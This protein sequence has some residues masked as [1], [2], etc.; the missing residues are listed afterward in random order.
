M[1]RA[2]DLRDLFNSQ[3][4]RAGIHRLGVSHIHMVAFAI[5][6]AH[7]GC[8]QG[9]QNEIILAAEGAAALGFED[10][11]HT[12]RL[13][14]N[15][16][17]FPDD[18][19]TPAKQLVGYF[20]PQQS[21]RRTSIDVVIGDETAFDQT[22]ISHDFKIG[23][24]TEQFN[25]RGFPAK[26]GADTAIDHRRHPFHMRRLEDIVDCRNVSHGQ[27]LFIAHI[28]GEVALKHKQQIGA[29]TAD[30]TQ[31]GILRAGADCQH[32]DYRGNADDDAKDGQC[33]AQFI[34]QDTLKRLPDRL[35]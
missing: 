11:N 31:N 26:A 1:A 2:Q 7:A 10:A 13:P 33:G 23:G 34:G 35:G 15:S 22:V 21:H 6:E 27:R 8:G 14:L 17:R 32:G 5:E 25:D 28:L 3:G 12:E 20:R 30:G 24:H 9:N 18:K 16:D 29:D 19:F 4:H